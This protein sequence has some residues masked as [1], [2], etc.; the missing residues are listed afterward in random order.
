[1]ALSKEVH[2]AEAEKK[3]ATV[4]LTEPFHPKVNHSTRA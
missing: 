2:R 3:G 1:M 4:D